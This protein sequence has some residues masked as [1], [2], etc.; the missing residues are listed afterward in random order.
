MDPIVSIESSVLIELALP[1]IV[2]FPP[3][4][5]VCV[6]ATLLVLVFVPILIFPVTLVV[7]ELDTEIWE[8]VAYLESS[9]TR[10][11]PFDSAAS[12]CGDLLF[13]AQGQ[14]HHDPPT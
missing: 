3:G 7:G 12:C 2:R 4:F 8:T 10:P 11:G 5:G 1:A 9:Q 6:V 13:V 14:R